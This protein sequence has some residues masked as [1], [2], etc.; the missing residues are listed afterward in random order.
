MP[1]SYR[2][3]VEFNDCACASLSC[4]LFIVGSPG[5]QQSTKKNEQVKTA[6]GRALKRSRVR[7]S[8]WDQIT[9]MDMSHI[10]HRIP[11]WDQSVSLGESGG[12]HPSSTSLLPRCAVKHGD[13]KSSPL[14]CV[15]F[16][17][18]HDLVVCCF[19]LVVSFSSSDL[20]AFGRSTTNPTQ[21]RL[22]TWKPCT[23][24]SQSPVTFVKAASQ[25][26]TC[27][28]SSVTARPFH[29]NRGTIPAEKSTARDSIPRATR[30]ACSS[31]F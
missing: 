30:P 23:N 4:F 22:G 29:S 16:F 21:A 3:V 24:N 13:V 17:F 18:L 26:C 12:Y 8:A 5:D 28:P 9:S 20:E 25:R 14:K 10:F 27:V 19:C 2:C 11:P 31:S 15:P 7:K 6:T 1:S